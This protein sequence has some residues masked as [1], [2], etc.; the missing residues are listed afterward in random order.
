MEFLSRFVYSCAVRLL[1]SSESQSACEYLFEQRKFYCFTRQA[2]PQVP[3]QRW[4]QVT[5]K[6]QGPVLSFFY[7]VPLAVLE[8]P[9]QAG[10]R[11]WSAG[12]FPHHCP[13]QGSFLTAD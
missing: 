9:A 11:L 8:T 4:W 13:I 12:S 6:S 5:R 7:C 1:R 10:L 3:G 2:N